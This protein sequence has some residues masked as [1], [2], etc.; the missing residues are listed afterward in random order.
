[1][2]ACVSTKPGTIVFPVTSITRAPAGASPRGPMLTMRLLRITMSAFSTISRS[3]IVIARAPR[4]TTVPCGM[5]LGA[6]TMTASSF[7]SNRFLP[8]E[9]SRAF[10]AGVVSFSISL[11]CASIARSKAKPESRS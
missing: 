10:P 9:S 6:R 7:A 11:R 1:M 5:S 8:S 3:F 4:S 2:C